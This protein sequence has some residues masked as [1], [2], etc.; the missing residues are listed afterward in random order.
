MAQGRGK[1]TPAFA[2]SS[3]TQRKTGGVRPL[4]LPKWLAGETNGRAMSNIERILQAYA[5]YIKPP[6]GKS[7][8][9][10]V[11]GAS[12]LCNRVHLLGDVP[13]FSEQ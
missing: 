4:R 12:G 11:R 7:S 8:F 13:S 9:K 5:T 6:G 2:F 1:T 10:L 3:N